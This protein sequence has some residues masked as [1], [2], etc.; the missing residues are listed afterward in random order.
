MSVLPDC[1]SFFDSLL[2]ISSCVFPGLLSHGQIKRDTAEV[3]LANDCLCSLLTDD[4]AI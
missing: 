3:I 4:D 1:S 2:E